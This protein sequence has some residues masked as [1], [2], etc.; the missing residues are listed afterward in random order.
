MNGVQKPPNGGTGVKGDYPPSSL[1]LRLMVVLCV[2]PVLIMFVYLSMFG[3]NVPYMDEWDEMHRVNS[4]L[5]G[6]HTLIELFEQHNEHRPAT[7]RIGKIFIGSLT[8]CNSKSEMIFTQLSMI[9]ALLVI[10]IEFRKIL[11]KKSYLIFFLPVPYIILSLRSWENI[12]WA[13][14]SCI[15]YCVL[16][17]LLTFHFLSKINSA[18]NKYNLPLQFFFGAVSAAAASFS[19]ISGL[20][21]WPAGFF[22][23]LVSGKINRTKMLLLWAAIGAV[24]FILY[25]H[26]YVKPSQ[27]PALDGFLKYPVATI[28]FFLY[29]T[30][31][32]LFSGTTVRL[33]SGFFI[34]AASL[35]LLLF[36]NRNF[37]QKYSFWIASLCYFLVTVILIAIGRAGLLPNYWTMTDRYIT[38]VLMIPICLYVIYLGLVSSGEKLNKLTGTIVIALSIFMLVSIINSFIDGYKSGRSEKLRREILAYYLS[39][40][41]Y[42]PDEVLERFQYPAPELLRESAAELEKL[43]YSVF[44]RPFLPPLGSLSALNSAALCSGVLNGEN[45][46]K[47]NGQ[48]VLDD[49]HN[50]M[51]I[52]G[53]AVDA[54]KKDIAGGIY[55]KIDEKLFPAFYGLYRADVGYQIKA[56]RTGFEIEIPVSLIDKGQHRLSIIVLTK[57]RRH[58]FMPRYDLAISRI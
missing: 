23:I 17:G 53:W 58:Y 50:I 43:Q 9:I 57:D 12:L 55:I 27:H 39:T 33:I 16:F 25:F 18:T 2:L 7:Q 29:T 40:Y 11:E 10:Y 13:N 24:V 44:Q 30:G 31:S 48:V 21:V 4:F 51:K 35:L 15:Y 6:R 1:I 41:R 54:V 42:Q 45:M 26:N 20:L 56:R 28:N 8:S 49:N 37:L 22:Q 46:N 5:Q 19:I 32:S 38:F 36:V 47:I 34:V 14:Q 52:E 3:V